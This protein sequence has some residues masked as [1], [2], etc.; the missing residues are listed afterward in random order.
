M[1]SHTNQNTVGL[2]GWV[3]A[4][5]VERLETQCA[6]YWYVLAIYKVQQYV[7]QPSCFTL[8]ISA[9]VADSCLL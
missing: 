6:Q 3:D 4:K 9:Y 5:S 8:F 2:G 7:T 1:H